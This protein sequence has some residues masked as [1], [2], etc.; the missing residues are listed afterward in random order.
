[1]TKP[2]AVIT[3]FGLKVNEVLPVFSLAVSPTPP[4]IPKYEGINGSTQGDKNES[5][6]A[7][8]IKKSGRSSTIFVIIVLCYSHVNL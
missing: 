2:A 6:P 3:R 7:A 8:K 4:K 5:N 1:M